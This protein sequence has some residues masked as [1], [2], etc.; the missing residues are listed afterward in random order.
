MEG[1]EAGGLAGPKVERIRVQLL[2]AEKQKE[3]RTQIEEV[4]QQRKD[5]SI[6]RA[7]NSIVE[8][9]VSICTPES[10][11]KRLSVRLPAVALARIDNVV[12]YC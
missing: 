1:G 5:E 6:L 9:A 12:T 3:L 2:A 4:E 8:S 7:H 10:T 11:R